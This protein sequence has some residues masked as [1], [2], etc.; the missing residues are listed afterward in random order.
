MTAFRDFAPI[1]FW[2]CWSV[3]DPSVHYVY[4][5]FESV[6][7]IEEV[8]KSDAFANLVEDYTNTWGDKVSRSREIMTITHQH[9]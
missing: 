3:S 8:S 6:E 4:Y 1:R 2:R 9:P 7:R 5:E